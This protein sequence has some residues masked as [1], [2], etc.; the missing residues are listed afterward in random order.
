[1]DIVPHCN[2]FSRV[3]RTSIPCAPAS[4]I[5]HSGTQFI[6]AGFFYLYSKNLTQLNV[7]YQQ[8]VKYQDT[9]YAIGLVSHI[10]E[11]RRAPTYETIIATLLTRNE[12]KT[13]MSPELV[14]AYAEAMRN[15]PR[16]TT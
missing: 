16:K 1:V 11:A 12:P 14:R 8:L 6:G 5:H 15:D 2:G 3:E 10:P 7:F 9:M 13:E 4:G